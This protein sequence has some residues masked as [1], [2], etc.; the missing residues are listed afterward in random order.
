LERRGLV[1][2]R[3]WKGISRRDQ[4]DAYLSHLKAETFPALGAIPGFVR[5]SILR[6]DVANGTEF[7][8]VTVWE[9][10]DAIRAFAGQDVELAVVPAVVRG[11]MVACEERATHYE[12]VHSTT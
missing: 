9:S 6:R 12:V 11:M 2:S 3:H 7:Q 4:S 10:L 8:V 1:I 5:A